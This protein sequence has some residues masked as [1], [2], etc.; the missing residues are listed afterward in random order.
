MAIKEVPK[1]FRYTCD[2]CGHFHIQE[3]ANGHYTNSTP[4]RWTTIRIILK[5]DGVTFEKLF[6]E[7]CSGLLE[8]IKNW[9]GKVK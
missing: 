3:N 5:Y 6:C 9:K 1:A 2:G 7:E 8:I 4:P